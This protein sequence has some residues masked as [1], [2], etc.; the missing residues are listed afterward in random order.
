[1]DEWE[2]LRELDRKVDE[3]RPLIVDLLDEYPPSEDVKGEMFCPICK[4]RLV[5]SVATNGHIWACCEN[6][7]CVRWQE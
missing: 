3:V 2:K 6:K 1:M 7:E 5:F 4:S